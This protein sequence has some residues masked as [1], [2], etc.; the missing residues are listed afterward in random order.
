M[1]K[2]LILFLIGS[3]AAFAKDPVVISHQ[4]IGVSELDKIEDE[5]IFSEKFSSEIG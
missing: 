1:K 2:I 3:C 5:F 4:G